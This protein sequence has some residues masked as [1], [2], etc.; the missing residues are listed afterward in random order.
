MTMVPM[1]QST[2]ICQQLQW[3][4]RPEELRVGKII[5]NGNSKSN[6]KIALALL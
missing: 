3:E 5:D 4:I 1:Q 6:K 2:P